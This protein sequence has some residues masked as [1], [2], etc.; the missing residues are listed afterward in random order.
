MF[1]GTLN[2]FLGIREIETS[3]YTEDEIAEGGPLRVTSPLCACEPAPEVE[4]DDRFR[5]TIGISQ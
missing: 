1:V 5:C 4:T 2:S 3:T